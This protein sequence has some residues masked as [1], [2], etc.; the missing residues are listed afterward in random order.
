MRTVVFFAI[1]MVMALS[2]APA[3]V[4][5]AISGLTRVATGVSNPL[6]VTHAPGD[7]SRLFIAERTGAIR[8]LNLETGIVEATPFL[9]M[10]GVSTTGEGGFLGLAFHPNYFNQGMP[11]FGKFYVNV[12]TNSTTETHIREFEVSAG[13]PNL[14]NSGSLREILSFSQPQ[15]NHN[16]GWLG[17]SPNNQYLY[18]AT[19]DG[20]GSDDN[21][22]GHTAGTGN[23]QDIT[24]NLLGKILRIDP[25]DPDPS[26]G[27]NYA[28]PPTNPFVGV[29]GDDEIWTYG[30]RN[31]FRSSFDRL[32]G[33]LW[34]GDVGQTARGD[35][36]STGL[37]LWRRELRL[38]AP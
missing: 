32:N 22:A 20:G 26:S 15:I 30:L 2:I 14:A 25:I 13:N 36:L 10:S 31:P 19:G 12:T 8:I 24:S 17:F 11:G 37:Q 23:A 33:N 38:A 1:V 29:T 4:R 21:D 9:T 7:R 16:G 34:I 6:F 5:A 18:I 35:R 28:I 3:S 27:L